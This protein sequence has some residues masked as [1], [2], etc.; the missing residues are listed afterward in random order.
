MAQ[1][2]HN[3]YNT[4]YDAKRFIG[5]KFSEKE[6]QEAQKQYPFKVKKNYLIVMLP[7]DLSV[8]T[9]NLDSLAN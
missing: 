7:L 2:E 8:K 1:S 5:K 9:L 6:V 3:P 4:L